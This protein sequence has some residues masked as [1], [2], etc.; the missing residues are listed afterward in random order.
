MNQSLFCHFRKTLLIVN[1]SESMNQVAMSLFACICIC[2]CVFAYVCLDSQ[3]S[4]DQCVV[5][6]A[7]SSSVLFVCTLLAQD[8]IMRFTIIYPNKTFVSVEVGIFSITH[9]RCG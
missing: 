8:L 7:L 9:V 2:F 1:T 5:Y 3:I 6:I 4:L